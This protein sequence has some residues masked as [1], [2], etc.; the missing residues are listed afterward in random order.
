MIELSKL[1]NINRKQ[2][3]LNLIKILKSTTKSVKKEKKKVFR[4]FLYSNML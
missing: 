1:Y 3:L 4:I 2:L